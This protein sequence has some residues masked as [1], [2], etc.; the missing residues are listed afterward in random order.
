MPRG[1]NKKYGIKGA[2]SS[3][4]SPRIQDKVIKPTTVNPDRDESFYSVI[5]SSSDDDF[6]TTI[7]Q[8]PMKKHIA[9]FVIVGFLKIIKANMGPV[10]CMSRLETR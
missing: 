9:S 10:H 4:R 7:R 8:T 6:T 2:L 3:Q 1:P 5:D